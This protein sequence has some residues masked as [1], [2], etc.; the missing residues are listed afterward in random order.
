MS[1]LT[2]IGVQFTPV[3]K[4]YSFSLPEGITTL[5]GASVIVNTNR[6]KQLGTVAQV[7]VETPARPEEVQV[8]ERLA[9]T[10]DLAYKEDLA[11]KEEL[12]VDATADFL[13]G[14]R[15]TG[16]KAVNAE[17]SF[18]ASRLTL[19]LNYEPDAGFDIKGFLR[20]SSRLFPGTRLE[21]RQVGPRDVAKAISGLGACGIEKRCCSRF[22]TEFRSIS[23]K[24]A[25]SQD[26]SLTPS[27]IT[28]ICGRLRCCLAYEHEA[29]EEARKHLPKRKK[30][31]QTPLGE[32]KV[33]QVLPMADAVMVDLPELGP[34]QFT[35]QE[36]ETGVMDVP[37]P[38]APEVHHYQPEAEDV[39]MVKLE[40]QPRRS[41][42][43]RTSR[44]DRSPEHGQRSDRREKT[45]TRSQQGSRAKGKSKNQPKSS[46]SQP[47]PAKTQEAGKGRSRRG[48]GRSRTDKNSGVN[49]S[50]SQNKGQDQGGSSNV[51]NG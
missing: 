24:M 40:R 45:G 49:P 15:F 44:P 4:I 10:E 36:L 50:S 31:V 6:G 8:I 37:A 28:G 1:E 13:R 51:T 46:A 30:V 23:I 7:N 35:S 11:K 41:E 2:Y 9:T 29:Y 39:E 38:A 32:G 47:Q 16:V 33:V 3:G 34:R 42:T 22:L 18:D 48:R 14:S 12:A 17:Y 19:F 21:V 5:V 20:E 26:I 43:S 25:K 27:E